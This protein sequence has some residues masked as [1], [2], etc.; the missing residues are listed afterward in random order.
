MWWQCG[1]DCGV[2]V[3]ASRV[4]VS[5]AGRSVCLRGFVVPRGTVW[6]LVV[7]P[8]LCVVISGRVCLICLGVGDCVFL[9]C[10][11]SCHQSRCGVL[12]VP[13]IGEPRRRDL[14]RV[15]VPVLI[16]SS[17]CAVGAVPFPSSSCAAS[18]PR[19]LLFSSVRLSCGGRRT[20]PPRLVLIELGKT[21]R[22]GIYRSSS[23]DVPGLLVPRL[24]ER[25]G[26]YLSS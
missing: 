7:P 19:C 24:V 13:V 25:L 17:S 23:S 14:P 3:P 2:L 4:I 16:I 10:S 8:V 6:A 20:L 26:P 18:S 21:A 22:D 12:V 15:P 11:C 5:T 1:D 9:S